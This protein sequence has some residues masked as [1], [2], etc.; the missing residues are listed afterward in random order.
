[1]RMLILRHSSRLRTSK[2]DDLF[3]HNWHYSLMLRRDIPKM[4]VFSTSPPCPLSEGEGENP[5]PFG[6]GQGWGA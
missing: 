1:M 2:I 4:S 6:E 5:L 3:E